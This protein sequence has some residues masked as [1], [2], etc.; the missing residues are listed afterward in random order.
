MQEQGSKKLPSNNARLNIEVQRLYLDNQN[1][2]TEIERL[3]IAIRQHRDQRGDDRCWQDD[4]KLYEALPEGL[5]K[6]ELGLP[7]PEEMLKNCKRY[8]TCRHQPGTPYISPQRRI[9]QL[10]ADNAR[11]RAAYTE[12]IFGMG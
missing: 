2:R 8:I 10:E 9:E 4:L 6:A 7:S 12:A 11:L 3:E 5:G 1:L